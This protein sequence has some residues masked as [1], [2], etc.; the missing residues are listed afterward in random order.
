M[1]SSK[2]Q[3]YFRRHFEWTALLLGLIV[4]ALMNPYVN[5]GP[6]FCFLEWIGIW[7][8]PGDGLGHSI[9]YFVRGDVSNALQANLLGPFAIFILLA[10]TGYLVKKNLLTKY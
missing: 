1:D 7:Y 10:R 6:S 9:A 3:Q 8:C 5:Q 4:I 2:I